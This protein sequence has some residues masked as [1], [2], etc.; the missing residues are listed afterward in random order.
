[1]K[2]TERNILV[3]VSWI[4]LTSYTTD[5]CMTRSCLIPY[6]S[7]SLG[8]IVFY[9]A[10]FCARFG[11]GHVTQ[12]ARVGICLIWLLFIEWHLDVNQNTKEFDWANKTKQFSNTYSAPFL[13]RKE[14]WLQN[15]RLHLDSKTSSLE[16]A[17]RTGKS[18]HVTWGNLQCEYWTGTRCQNKS[19]KLPLR[20]KICMQTSSNSQFTGNESITR[21]RKGYDPR[22]VSTCWPTCLTHDIG[23]LIA[24][25]LT[26][27]A[28]LLSSAVTSPG[29]H[30]TLPK[31]PWDT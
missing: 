3:T 8:C 1:M 29:L 4:L 15:K 10:W 12:P 31:I 9:L 2:Q 11:R 28:G 18:S 6:L 21:L 19:R 16:Q 20:F 5:C 22:L 24:A 23:H 7:C 27:H 26:Q 17:P 14:L 13:Q 25:E 30:M